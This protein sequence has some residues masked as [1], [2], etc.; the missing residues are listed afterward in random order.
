[1]NEWYE[2]D[3][4]KCGRC[5]ALYEWVRPGKSQDTCDCWSICPVHGQ[6]AIQYHTEGERPSIAGYYCMKC[7]RAA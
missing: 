3:P 6:G 4:G 7:E 2:L 5:G 1:M